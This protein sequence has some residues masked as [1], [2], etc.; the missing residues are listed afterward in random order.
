MSTSVAYETYSPS[1][2][3]KD[4]KSALQPVKGTVPREMIP[5]QYDNNEEGLKTA[6]IELTNPLDP[7]AENIER[8]KVVYEIFC[9]M[10]HGE[11]GIGDGLLFTSEKF[12]IQPTS[13]LVEKST[14]RPDGEIYHIITHG[15]VAMGSHAAQIKPNDRWKVILYVRN[16]LEKKAS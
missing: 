5:Y 12:P 1:L 6:G 2:V 16:V 8:G 10:C 15:G 4:G 3:F 11:T 9:N 14:S 13:L 7:S